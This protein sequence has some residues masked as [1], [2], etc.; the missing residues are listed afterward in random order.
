[1]LDRIEQPE[2]AADAVRPAPPRWRRRASTAAL[3]LCLLY[4]LGAVGVWLFLRQAGDYWWPATFLLF[5]PRW[6]WIVPM[7][8]LLPLTLLF[9]RR[10]TW[11]PVMTGIFVLFELMG[12]CIPWRLAMSQPGGKGTVRI[13]TANLHARE[14]N[15]A[16]VNDF[17]TRTQPDVI[18]LEEYDPRMVLPYVRRPGWHLDYGGSMLIASRWPLGL[19]KALNLEEPPQTAEELDTRINIWGTAMRWIV[20]SPAGTFQLVGLHLISPHAALSMTRKDRDRAEQLLDDNAAR[21]LHE[22]D[23]LRKRIAEVP[24]STVI[25]GDFNTTD[26]SPIFRETFP[27]YSDAFS[28]AG[29]G[30]GTSYVKHRTWLRIDHI[31]FDSTWGC[32]RCYTS[33][34]V[35]SG[36]RAVL[37]E[38]TR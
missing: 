24:G 10:W 14:A 3:I 12:F 35:G 4:A 23:V 9:R 17:L 11:L 27:D 20:Y 1:M 38:L 22:L 28:V 8:L 5:S 31:L 32:R 15:A 37:A 21:R 13:V 30:F 26:D 29:L 34:D 18:V 25:V 33:A 2:H 19:S 36:H 6:V 16:I 7:F